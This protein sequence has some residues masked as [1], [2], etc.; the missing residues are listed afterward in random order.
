[1]VTFYES[2]PGPRR[3]NLTTANIWKFVRPHRNGVL[4]KYG[5]GDP[6]PTGFVFLPNWQGSVHST[7]CHPQIR[8]PV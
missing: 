7:V 2:G 3:M 4:L 1:M 5:R 6:A 8:T